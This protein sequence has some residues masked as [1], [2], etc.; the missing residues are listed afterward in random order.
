MEDECDDDPF[1]D[2]FGD[3]LHVSSGLQTT[4][5]SSAVD[6]ESV[7]GAETSMAPARVR[8]AMF[9]V[10]DEAKTIDGMKDVEKET[11]DDEGTRFSVS[12][13]VN[14]SGEVHNVSGLETLED[15]ALDRDHYTSKVLLCARTKRPGLCSENESDAHGER[16]LD[17]QGIEHSMQT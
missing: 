9:H 7:G 13:R 14:Y 8:K 12:Y 17:V 3:A 16:A 15:C 5:D 10:L 1:D 11:T 6:D 2:P 4:R